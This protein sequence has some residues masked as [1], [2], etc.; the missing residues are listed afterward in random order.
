MKKIALIILF[1]FFQFS[2]PRVFGSDGDK[3]LTGGFTGIKYKGKGKNKELVYLFDYEKM[4]E[5]YK[6]F[7]KDT[8]NGVPFNEDLK[9]KISETFNAGINH[10]L[11]KLKGCMGGDY[12]KKIENKA[13]TGEIEL[14]I[15]V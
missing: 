13:K 14:R 5:L 7:L 1:I 15:K 3:Y 4:K 9:K 2:H 6:D 8:A 12:S 11:E 10:Q